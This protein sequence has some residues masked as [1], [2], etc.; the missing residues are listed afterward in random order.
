MT[1]DT[2][3]LLDTCAVLFISNGS[4]IDDAADLAIGGAASDN[5]LFVSPMSAWELGVGVAKG[6]FIL[7]AGPLEFFNRF[8]ARIGAKLSA[9]TPDILV[10]SSHLPGALHKDPIDR[11]LVATARSLDMIL[12]TRD[13][14]VLAYGQAGHVRTL[15]C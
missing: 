14:P 12:V 7:P 8:V 2:A 6:R 9:V 10:G 4:R 15:A 3:V 1:D 5:R 11:I 13:A